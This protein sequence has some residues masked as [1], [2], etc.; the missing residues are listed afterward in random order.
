MM[1]GV[2]EPA[3]GGV[4]TRGAVFGMIAL[5]AEVS[6]PVVGLAV[7]GTS[8]GTVGSGLDEFGFEEPGV[9][10]SGALVSTEGLSVVD[11]AVVN[12]GAEVDGTG[13]D[14]P[15]GGSG[16]F[17]ERVT[18]GAVL[19]SHEPFTAHISVPLKPSFAVKY[20]TLL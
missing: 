4:S 1:L 16:A 7:V 13:R 15:D 12:T 5:G 8:F 11:G 14:T 3:G 19:A 17:S 18:F 9:D 2:D 10:V 20:K 6:E